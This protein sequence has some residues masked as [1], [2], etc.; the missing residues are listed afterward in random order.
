[1]ALFTRLY[2]MHSQQN[3]KRLYQ[4]GENPKLSREW[5]CNKYWGFSIHTNVFNTYFKV[6]LQ[7][8]ILGEQKQI[9]SEGNCDVIFITWYND[10][11][12]ALYTSQEMNAE[13]PPFIYLETL[14]NWKSDTFITKCVTSYSLQI[15]LN[16]PINTQWSTLDMHS[17]TSCLPSIKAVV[18]IFQSKLKLKSW[19]FQ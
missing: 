17:G 12:I 4:I 14:K 15:F 2:R 3:I 16:I 9:L 8:S 19:K 10:T 1:L 11:L 5:V 7:T 18:Y 6:I 13:W